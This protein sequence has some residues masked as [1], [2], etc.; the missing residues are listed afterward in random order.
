MGDYSLFT[1]ITHRH[2]GLCLP[3]DRYIGFWAVWFCRGAE[4]QKATGDY[5]TQP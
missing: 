5:S 2:Q 4:L 3:G 1:D